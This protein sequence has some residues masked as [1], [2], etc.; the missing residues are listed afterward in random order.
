[1]KE[2]KQIPAL[3]LSIDRI[4]FRQL[5]KRLMQKNAKKCIFMLDGGDTPCYHVHVMRETPANGKDKNMAPN[6]RD[7]GK[8]DLHIYLPIELFMKLKKRAAQ[9][10]VTM[11]ELV[12][13]SIIQETKNI[14]LTEQDYEEIFNFKNRRRH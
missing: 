4:M 7:V 11:V 9:L 14:K 8:K 5:E 13:L 6:Q 3:S 12:T 2:K 10:N 1:M